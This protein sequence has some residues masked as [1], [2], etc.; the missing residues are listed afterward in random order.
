MPI[1]FMKSSI[2]IEAGAALVPEV[3]SLADG[4]TQFAQTDEEVNTSSP[5]L[6]PGETFCKNT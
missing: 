3:N 1:P 5:K 6:Y 4:W 2:A